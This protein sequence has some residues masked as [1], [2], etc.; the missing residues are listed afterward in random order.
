MAKSK[1]DIP[2]DGVGEKRRLSRK[3]D[4]PLDSNKGAAGI[5]D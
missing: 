5:T 3:I 2:L 4:I 1:I